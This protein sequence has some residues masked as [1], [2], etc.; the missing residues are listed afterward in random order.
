MS[1][2]T[3]GRYYTAKFYRELT[4]AQE[5]AR[6]VL[7]IIFRV[8][9]PATIV[10]IGCGT[11][12]WLAAAH[13]LGV[14]NIFGVDGL[15]VDKAELAIPATN[16]SARDLATPLDLGRRFDLA[17]CFEVA[18]HLPETA[19][20]TLVQGLCTAA[21]I[22]AFS[23]AIPGQGGRHHLNEQWPAYW[24]AL[25]REFRYDCFDYLRP[26]IWNNPRVAWYYAQ[27]SLIFVRSGVGHSF[28][29]PTEPMSLVHPE[30]WSA[31][32]ARSRHPGKLLERFARA[33][34]A[35]KR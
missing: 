9:K 6:E 11:G 17:L 19:A 5:S 30:L 4:S 16:F 2:D 26:R 28:G 32:V 3:A 25:F 12:H 13:E 27:N 14:T 34:L 20:R 29:Q 10:D 22:V 15:W 33:I 23:A 8:I 1:K 31:E 24:A 21:D 18:E 35:R 7:P